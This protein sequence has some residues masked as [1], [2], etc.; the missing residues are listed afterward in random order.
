VRWL[1]LGLVWTALALTLLSPSLATVVEGLPNDHYHAFA[2]P[3]VFVLVGVGA[4]ALWRARPQTLAA[5]RLLAV[6]GVVAVTGWAVTHQ[7]PSV[8]PDGG[9]PA[10]E[11]AAQ[12]IEQ[13]NIDPIELGSL[14]V[15]KTP[16][17]YEYPLV[18]DGRI[19]VAAN[20]DRAAP[21][22][23]GETL[24]VVCDSLFDEVIGAPCGGQAEAGVVP[25]AFGDPRDR[26]RAAPRQVISVYRAPQGVA[27]R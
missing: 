26:F 24:V 23:A 6:V 21:V 1:A 15:F 8:A 19:V 4:A 22:I 14:P 27:V 11:A 9:F 20:L 3:M 18:R 7:P 25:T 17:A 2:D 16:E 5:G 13:G 10:A 12:R